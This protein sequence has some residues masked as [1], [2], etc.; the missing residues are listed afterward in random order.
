MIYADGLFHRALIQGVDVKVSAY[1]ST[2]NFTRE[3][4]F[5]FFSSYEQRMGYVER[6]L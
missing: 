6:L 3:Q 2:R 5:S 1:I 4:I